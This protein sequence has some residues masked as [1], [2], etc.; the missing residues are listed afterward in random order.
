MIICR[1]CGGLGNQMF[2]YA[3]SYVLARRLQTK[4]TLD[5]DYYSNFGNDTKRH[6]GLKIFN[7]SAGLATKEDINKC[8]NISSF[9]KINKLLNRFDFNPHLIKEKEAFIFKEIKSLKTNINY[10]VDGYWQNAKYFQ[11]ES[12]EIKQEFS[13]RRESNPFLTSQQLVSLINS[14]GFSKSV[15][16]HIRRGDYVNGIDKPQGFFGLNYYREA[17]TIMRKQ[18]VTPLWLIFSDDPAWVKE[19]IS[20]LGLTTDDQII[21]ADQYQLGDYDLLLMSY[22]HH[23]IIANST[24]SWWS[25]WLNSSPDKV[26]IGPKRWIKGAD[27]NTSDILPKT[28]LSL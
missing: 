18:V 5:V 16:I 7:I 1:L 9:T 22:C 24:F 19:N 13:L 3:T 6:F 21:F 10:Y 12:A 8:L 20:G 25:A 17:I 14:S 4:L 15:G 23:Q 26:V 11:N 2:Q 28:W 27:F